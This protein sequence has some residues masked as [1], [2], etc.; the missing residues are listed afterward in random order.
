MHI[1][2]STILLL[3]PTLT[4]ST[5]HLPL[6]PISPLQPRT[7]GSLSTPRNR[8]C[9]VTALGNSQDDSAA[10]LSAIASCNNGGVVEL[11]SPLYTIA[12]PLNLTYLSS[13]DFSIHGTIAFSPNVSFWSTASFKYP[14]QDSAAFIQFGGT[15]VNFYGDGQ[16]VIDGNGQVWYDAFAK[17]SDVVRPIL[18][19]LNGLKGGSMSGLTMKNSPMWFNFFVGVQDFVVSGMLLEASSSSKSAVKNTG[20]FF[21]SWSWRKRM[22]RGKRC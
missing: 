16:G 14:F 21:R 8:T 20:E 10:L 9:A 7:P 2:L 13:I 12:K 5:P 6:I 1:P 17:N 3:L 11:H 4:L 22:K 18:W 19:V 15:D